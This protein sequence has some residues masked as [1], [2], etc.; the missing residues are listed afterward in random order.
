MFPVEFGRRWNIFWPLMLI[1]S[2]S[3]FRPSSWYGK[4]GRWGQRMVLS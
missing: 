4:G 3:W 1:I 2:D